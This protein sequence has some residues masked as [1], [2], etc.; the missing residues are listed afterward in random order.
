[1]HMIGHEAVAEDAQAMLATLRLEGLQVEEAVAVGAKDR[2]AI[3]A[4]LGDVVGRSD[5]D[6]TFLSGHASATLLLRTDRRK[7]L[8]Y[9]EIV[10]FVP[11]P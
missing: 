3:V 1:M 5:D 2:L 10:N 8:M 6:E 4:A 9:K 7:P 11:V